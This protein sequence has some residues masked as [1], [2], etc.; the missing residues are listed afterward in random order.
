[1]LA[2]QHEHVRAKHLGASDVGGIIPPGPEEATREAE[3]VGKKRSDGNLGGGIN[4]CLP[5]I[6]Q[7]RN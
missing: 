2:R 1:M 5:V 3:T 7:G 6:G 4:H